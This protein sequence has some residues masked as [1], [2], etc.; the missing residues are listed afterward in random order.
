MVSIHRAKGSVDSCAVHNLAPFKPRKELYRYVL[1][2]APVN[3]QN[4]KSWARIH[5]PA[6]DAVRKAILSQPDEM[7]RSAFMEL[8]ISWDRMMTSA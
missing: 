6:D 4:L 5:L 1:N 3:L 8:A 7:P 2:N